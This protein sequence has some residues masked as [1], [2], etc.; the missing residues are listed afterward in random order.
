MKR[1]AIL[2]L[3]GTL[4]L[5]GCTSIPEYD[6][7]EYTQLTKEQID[8]NAQE[9]FGVTFSPNQDWRMTTVGTVSI[10]ADADFGTI[11]KVQVLTE[12]PFL[13]DNA[14]VLNSANVSNG[15]TATLSYE[16]PKGYT[17]LVAACVNSD[18]EYYIKP[19]TLGTPKVS[20]ARN[21]RAMTRSGQTVSISPKKIRLEYK[22]SLISYNAMRTI[23]AMYDRGNENTKKWLDSDFENERLWRPSNMSQSADG[24]VINNGSIYRTTDA[25]DSDDE[26]ALNTILDSYLGGKMNLSNHNW[27]NME[28]VRN[29]NIF[30]TSDNYLT[31]DGNPLIITP[32]N[33]T[34]T[35]MSKF[36]LNIYYFYFNPN[37][38]AGKS[39][40]EQVKFLKA[41]PKF[42]AIHLNNYK[43]DLDSKSF[44]KADEY[45]L[46]YYGD[47][48]FDQLGMMGIDEE[49]E[50][51][52]EV[53]RIKN[54]MQLEGV[55]YYMT[56]CGE[57]V[58]N[59]IQRMA[60]KYADND[61]LIKNQLWQIFVAKNDAKKMLLYNLGSKK[62]LCW[63]DGYNTNFFD[64][65]SKVLNNTFTIDD[66][67]HIWRYKNTSLRLGTDLVTAAGKAMNY[68][69]W[70]DKK[71]DDGS[72]QWT[73][74][75]FGNNSLAE[76]NPSVYE[77]NDI[78]AEDVAIPAGYKVGFMH[79]KGNDA[80]SNS[81]KDT[82]KGETYGD[83]R[84]NTYI[85]QF[86]DFKSAINFGMELNDPRIAIFRAND[87][88]Y[89]SFEDGT[90][91]NFT[92]AFIEINSGIT[93]EPDP[94]KVKGQ[95]Y[96]YCF[97]DHLDG[98]YDMNDVIVKATRLDETHILYSLEACGGYD[99]LYLRNINGKL[100]NG[101]TEIHQ[102]F[103]VPQH[104]FVNTQGGNHQDPIQEIIEVSPDFEL[105]EISENQICIYN[106][107]TD[108]VIKLS[109]VGEA[110]LGL[111]IPTDFE[112]PLETTNLKDAHSDFIDWIGNGGSNSF[113]YASP[114][115]TKVYGSKG[116]FI[117]PSTQTAYPEFF[118]NY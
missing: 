94:I 115:S 24:W 93:K 2:T 69:I 63:I 29:T 99:E 10:T 110:P 38:I 31:A 97:E 118:D 12:S 66:K 82:N 40:D 86:P 50:T 91:T 19:F 9:V 17:T 64:E 67:G 80:D 75:A 42:K 61:I 58:A 106:K 34:S 73:F 89:M 62:F 57:G 109:D 83:G 44:F 1:L 48:L 15:E 72:T 59:T 49:Y 74:E 56:F 45:L 102:M 36:Y 54:G 25:L 78:L 26:E 11:K 3:A 16:A 22:N 21:T 18:G 7:A 79:R 70:S 98:D 51:N 68:G 41:L 88:R 112:Y 71:V 27:Q 28:S 104:S 92:D 117:L 30:Q 85:N 101:N 107:T 105:G 65:K 32:I 87:K 20:F 14:T 116:F 53:V 114:E 46:P 84:L 76:N 60:P 5:C 100:L 33:A 43:S 35:D 6:Q 111:M 8:K 39:N 4:T 103:G 113:W 23:E 108:T 47:N 77:Y 90:D 52:G 81:Y 37:E 13:N 95:I 55:D 96:T